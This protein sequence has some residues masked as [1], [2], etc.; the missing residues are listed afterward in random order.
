LLKQPK[1]HR[2]TCARFL[3]RFR[4]P[5][6]ATAVGLAF[7]PAPQDAFAG[8]VLAC[9]A[10]PLLRPLVTARRSAARTA[11]LQ[12]GAVADPARLLSWTGDDPMVRGAVLCR[13]G[14]YDEAVQVLGDNHDITALLYRALA[15][16]GRGRA[17]AARAALQEADRLLAK[18]STD[19]SQQTNAA[20][21][22][23][24]RRAE[25][26]LLRTEGRALFPGE[27]P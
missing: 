22:S 13:A 21:L 15:E 3:E 20:R 4:Y 18:A 27:K 23:W 8:G 11:L 24:D 19:D 16:H 5:P 1:E 25:A 17:V 7:A 6:E 12:R 9:L 26:E 14:R 2:Q 10:E